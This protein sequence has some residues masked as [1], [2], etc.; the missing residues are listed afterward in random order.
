MGLYDYISGISV[1]IY[2]FIFLIILNS[3][4]S[5]I[6][7][8]F[9][10]LI[11]ISLIWTGG[12]LLMRKQAFPTYAFWYH[13]SLMGVLAMPIIYFR[14]IMEYIGNVKRLYISIYAILMGAAFVVNVQTGL[15]IPPPVIEVV[16]GTQVMVYETLEWPIYILF[17]L[18][19]FMV[20]HMLWWFY[21]GV[22]NNLKLRRLSRPITVAIVVTFIGNALVLFPAFSS[23]PID[24][25]SG[26]VN[27]LALLYALM[28]KSPFRLKML[29]SESVGYAICL[30]LG[31]LSLYILNPVIDSMLTK[32]TF[33][34]DSR[35]VL[36]L[37]LFSL[38]LVGYFVVW[39]MVIVGIFVKD[40][41]EKSELLNL[42]S[43]NITKSLDS[44]HIFRQTINIIEQVVGSHNVYFA[45]KTSNNAFRLTYSNQALADLSV[46]FRSD[47][48]LVKHL[49]KKNSAVIISEFRFDASYQTMWEQEKY[50]LVKLDI[51]HAFGLVDD[52]EIHGVLLMSDAHSKKSLK[53]QQILKLQSIC[54][55]VS[56][57][58]KNAASYEKAVIESRTDDLT[59]LY[60]RKYFYQLIDEKF[61]EQKSDSLALVMLN[62][63][64]FKLYNQLYGEKKADQA[65]E[66]IATILKGSVGKGGYVARFSGKEFAIVLPRYDVHRTLKLVEK[67]TQQI[68]EY[69]HPKVKRL[70][71]HVTTSIGVCVYPFGASNVKEL[72]ENVQQAVYQV[73]RNGK[74]SVRVFDTFVQKEDVS[75]KRSYSSI[76]NEY[77]STIYALTAAIDA[78][79]HY[80][81]S[82]SEN[83][84]KYAVAFAKELNLNSDIVENIRQAALLHDIGKISIPEQVLNKPGSL[85]SEEYRLIQGH[86][87]ASI[88][89]I[90]HLPSLD[91]VI[92]AV[93]GHHERYDGTGYPR[94]TRG[95]DIP[96]TARILCLADSFD[97][98]VSGRVYMD[99][100][101]IHK[102]IEIIEKEAGKQFDPKLATVFVDML[103]R[104]KIKVDQPTIVSTP[105]IETYQE[106]RKAYVGE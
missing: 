99:P 23:F 10:G 55:M 78:K 83:V 81:F 98:M 40:E 18:G 38:L 34:S 93:L 58:L 104:G 69:G 24:I 32:I 71:K 50:D 8:V 82:H 16:D 74:N 91:Y 59:G 80:T 19:V 66:V 68:F 29:V 37:A 25:L 13:V 47:N 64:D 77:K 75:E 102:V 9:L 45:L 41:E 54:T 65:L 106:I 3:K 61:I 2:F 5:K 92:P 12:S 26:V 52:A 87:D 31:F 43:A 22:S 20:I 51:T 84:A 35:I 79:D 97:V 15:F 53:H 88:D 48:P 90:R 67:V 42:F 44:E 6:R 28:K 21:K 11:M 95:E 4:K 63:D 14:F 89:I 49:S 56:I 62:L 103:K 94:R 46:S 72:I 39:K 73:K 33:T 105:K 17:T 27:A 60:N 100:K 101:P 57:A 30:L 1:L 85:T 86:V 36:Y 7:N 70:E 76:Y 96:I